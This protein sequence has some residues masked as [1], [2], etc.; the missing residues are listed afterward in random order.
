M[1][2]GGFTRM[3]LGSVVTAAVRPD[4]MAALSAPL[5]FSTKSCTA[6]APDSRGGRG[7]QRET[8]PFSI[9]PFSVSRQ[10]VLRTNP[11]AEHSCLRCGHKSAMASRAAALQRARG[12]RPAT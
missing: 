2:E 12:A 11:D 5:L 6:R 7:E 10:S 3:V 9:L 4:C 1:V 8:R